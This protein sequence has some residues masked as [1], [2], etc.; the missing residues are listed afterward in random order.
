MGPPCR[1]DLSRMI[2]L[3]LRGGDHAGDGVVE[4]HSATQVTLYKSGAQLYATKTSRRP[5]R[6][7]RLR[8]FSGVSGTRTSH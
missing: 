4:A 7:T 1:S 6:G 2:L 8:L 5:M 3:T